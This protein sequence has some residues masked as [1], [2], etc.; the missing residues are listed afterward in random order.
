[1]YKQGTVE[2]MFLSEVVSKSWVIIV[3]IGILMGSIYAVAIS[4][5]DIGPFCVMYSFKEGAGEVFSLII[6]FGIWMKYFKK[7]IIVW[8]TSCFQITYPIACILV[9][10]NIFSYGFAAISLFVLPN[11]Y[12][13]VLVISVFCIQCIIEIGTNLF[14]LCYRKQ[15]DFSEKQKKTKTFIKILI[16][17][18]FASVVLTIVNY[19]M[20][21]IIS[22]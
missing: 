14:I 7:I 13:K 22:L 1:M 9:C 12:L 5:Y 21:Y 3:I 20:M 16:I 17:T 18:M 19:G 10:S 4:Q 11:G 2:K 8:L 6:L 15:S